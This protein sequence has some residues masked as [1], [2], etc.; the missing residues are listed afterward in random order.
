MEICVEAVVHGMDGGNVSPHPAP[1]PNDRA[2]RRLAVDQQLGVI[3]AR[4]R[5]L[6]EFFQQR[7]RCSHCIRV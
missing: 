4:R 3:A 2:E 1:H 5:E 7:Y 6:R